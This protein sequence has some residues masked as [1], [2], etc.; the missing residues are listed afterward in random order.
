M[1]FRTSPGPTLYEYDLV[2][3]PINLSV[4]MHINIP[5]LHFMNSNIVVSVYN[6]T[7]NIESMG[8]SGLVRS[9]TLSFNLFEFVN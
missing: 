5:T 1:G 9:H 7:T 8:V 6:E 2:E 4:L 3:V